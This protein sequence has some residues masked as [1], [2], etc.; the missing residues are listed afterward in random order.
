MLKFLKKRESTKT[1]I[2]ACSK[3]TI[4]PLEQVQ[5]PVFSQRLMGDGIAINVEEDTIY[6]PVDGEIT[7]IA[8][9]SH[10][11][12][13]TLP[14]GIELMIHVGLETVSLKGEGFIPLVTVGQKVH[15][16]EPILRIDVKFMKQNNIELITPIIILNQADKTL[17]HKQYDT[18]VHKDTPL[19]E[20][21]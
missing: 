21:S 6:A 13:L 2:C 16:G 11:F 10:A 14:S 4:V 5:D 9:T 17:T 7:L 1:I 19:L 8:E 18:H 12:G 3:G 20:L 15:Q